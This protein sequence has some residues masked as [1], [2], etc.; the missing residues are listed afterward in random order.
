MK[1]EK[2]NESQIRCTLTKEDLAS[3]Q[4]RVS[5]LAYGSD[6]ARELF[7]EMMQKASFQFGFEADN[8]PLM[9]EAV[10]INSDCLVLIITKSDDPEE[11]DTRFS[12]FAPSVHESDDEDD[13]DDDDID[14]NYDEIY[15]TESSD[16]STTDINKEISDLFRSIS[17]GIDKKSSEN[18]D[19]KKL[20]Q[21]KRNPSSSE[22]KTSTGVTAFRFN[23][24][25]NVIQA[26]S[27]IGS[28][29]SGKSSIYKDSKDNSIILVLNE[30]DDKAALTKTIGT[31]SEYC[32]GTLTVNTLFLDGH[33][34]IIIRNN[35]I[36]T[37]AAL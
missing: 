26:A 6:K 19:A 1:I 15:D 18:V 31:I 16:G 3:R 10:P 9:V 36:Q 24:I 33:S 34:H 2:V 21:V 23:T 35:A 11:L 27:A 12:E 5:E 4:I 7:Q 29:F 8:S 25:H 14:G 13:S 30:T 17:S 37:L 22:V 32:N 28:S 20:A